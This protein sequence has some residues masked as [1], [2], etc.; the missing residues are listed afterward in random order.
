MRRILICA[1]LHL[2]AVLSA[3]VSINNDRALPHASAMLEVKS[4]NKGFLPP[5]MSWP[6]IQAIQNP[7]TGLVVFDEGLKALRIYDGV[8]W[9]VIGPKEYELTDPPGDFST[10]MN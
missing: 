9:V 7:A 6:Q 4:N 10:F 3:Q 5:K 8:K 2:S 1:A